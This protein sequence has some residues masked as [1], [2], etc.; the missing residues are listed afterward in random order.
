MGC[1]FK[2]RLVSSRHRGGEVVRYFIAVMAA[3]GT[4]MCRR[5]IL[6]QAA[7]T[8]FRIIPC[9][10][11]PYTTL[12]IHFRAIEIEVVRQTLELK[13]SYRVASATSDESLNDIT[14]SN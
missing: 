4:M 12:S 1:D 2:R 6:Q 3:Q 9:E 8:H 5:T 10:S 7:K 11:K 14:A 13:F